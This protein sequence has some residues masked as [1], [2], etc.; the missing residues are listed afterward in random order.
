MTPRHRL[1]FTLADEIGLTRDDRL[2][3]AEILLRRDV[4][5]WSDLDEAELSRLLDALHGWIYVNALVAHHVG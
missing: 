1:A 5:S 4:A 2:D 3:L